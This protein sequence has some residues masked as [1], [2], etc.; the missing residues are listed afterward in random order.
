[1]TLLGDCEG[2]VRVRFTNAGLGAVD[3]R[4]DLETNIEEL[5]SKEIGP[6]VRVEKTLSACFH[7]VFC[8]TEVTLYTYWSGGNT[9]PRSGQPPRRW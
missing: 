9:Q 3:R 2:K 5:A 8:I 4:V 6:K 7:G 1:M